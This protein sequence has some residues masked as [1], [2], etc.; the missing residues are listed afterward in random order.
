MPRVWF[1]PT[2][3]T[4]WHERR[5]S[6]EKMNDGDPSR[7]ITRCGS[8]EH[9][10]ESDEAP[11]LTIEISDRLLANA[12]S[13]RS[14]QHQVKQRISKAN[15]EVTIHDVRRCTI[16]EVPEEVRQWIVL[17]FSR[18]EQDEN[19]RKK[20]RFRKLVKAMNMHIR[21]QKMFTIKQDVISDQL[22][23]YLSE[24]DNWGWN[25]FKA[26]ELTNGHPLHYSMLELFRK[27]NINSRFGIKQTTLINFAD[28]IE[29]EYQ[30]SGAPYHNNIHATDVMVTVHQ[31]LFQTQMAHC[32]LELFSIL[33]AAAIHDLAH[34]G[35]SNQFHINTKSNLALLY[36]DQSVLE[37]HHIS[38][39]FRIMK[40]EE[41]KDL[42]SSLNDAQYKEFRS[43]VI[44]MV[45]STDMSTHFDKIKTIK[46]AIR[47]PKEYWNNV[48]VDKSAEYPRTMEKIRI[49]ELL[50]HSA[51]LSNCVKPWKFHSKSAT[52][53]L[54]E[55]FRQGDIEKANDIPVSLL[56]D[57]V[58]TDVPKSQIGF[59]AYIIE[60]TFAIL[61][62]T[63]FFIAVTF[64]PVVLE[65]DQ[66]KSRIST[67]KNFKAIRNS[68]INHEDVLP[69]IDKFSSIWM[70]HLTENRMKW[71]SF[72]AQGSVSLDKVNEIL[73]A[74]Q[75]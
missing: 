48:L 74:Q 56:C 13:E 51:D 23:D 27:Y 25:P 24:I 54:E 64:L 63:A 29:E 67:E 39:A 53:L 61:T 19:E 66:V 49:M 45:L 12:G 58:T 16:T 33:F 30:V 26:G 6:D 9:P 32:D 44:A 57:R 41:D 37:N 15:S 18:Q 36:N 70:E 4:E 42:T 75:E 28:A 35:Q 60:P 20:G 62:E 69:I 71:A 3:M 52:L 31:L 7:R 50:L 68:D 73:E 5:L 47:M 8:H 40:T 55:F 21:L 22:S 38:T 65:E 72:E 11:V 10:G 43:N 46:S 2:P 59:M 14:N 1:A 34:T 17:T